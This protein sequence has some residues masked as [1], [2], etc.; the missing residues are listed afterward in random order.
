MWTAIIGSLMALVLAGRSLRSF[1]LSQAKTI[2][3]A[4]IWIAIIAGLTL[5]IG[6]LKP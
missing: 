4:L 2:Q 1:R 3:L 5:A 6:Y